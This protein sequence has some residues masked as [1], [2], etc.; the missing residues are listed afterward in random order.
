MTR[1]LVAGLGHAPNQSGITLRDPS[2]REKCRFY[3]GIAQQRENAVDVLLDPAGHRF[4]FAA[5]YVGSEGRDLKIIL[6]VDRERVDDRVRGTR[7]GNHGRL[8]VFLTSRRA[9][10]PAR[11]SAMR[12]A[13]LPSYSSGRRPRLPPVRRI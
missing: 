11:C 1:K 8:T 13:A 6:D 3:V 7:V 10:H 5:P 9:S 4:P 12:I 2:Q